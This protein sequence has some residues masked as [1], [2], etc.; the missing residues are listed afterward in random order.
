[1]S[2]LDIVIPVYNEGEMIHKVLDSFVEHIKTPYRVLICYD[3]DE[4]NT[5]EALKIFDKADQVDVELVKNQGKFAHG[6]VMSGFAASKA[7]FVLTFPADDAHNAINIDAMVDRAQSGGPDG[8][9]CDIVCASRFMKGGCMEGAPWLKAFLVRSASFTLYH[10]ARM[11]THDSSNG[12]RLFSR[13][14]IESIPIESTLGFCF[15]I[16]LL[17]KCHRL[18]WPIGESPSQWYERTV[19]QSR[20]KVLKWL[21]QY[22]RWYFYAFMTTFL[23]ARKVELKQSPGSATLENESQQETPDG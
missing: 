15:S 3:H 11:P 10:I 1:M 12:L 20:F 9:G 2:T 8:T 14:V 19:G 7:P 23:R 16:E 18:R 17:V 13:R 22:L 6:A 21:P 5:L 4:D